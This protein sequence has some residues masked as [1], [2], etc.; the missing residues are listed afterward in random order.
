MCSDELSTCE[1]PRHRLRAASV[2]ARRICPT[3]DEEEARDTVLAGLGEVPAAVLVEDR[4]ATAT[5]IS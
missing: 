1:R 3:L 4:V 2:T 5:R